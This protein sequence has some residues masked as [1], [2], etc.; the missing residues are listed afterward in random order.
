MAVY[1]IFPEK[2]ATMYTEFP[3]KNTGLDQLLEASTY[4]SEATPQ[5]SRYLIKFPTSQIAEMFNSKI[6]NGEYK[7]YLK[8]FNA[9]VTGLNLDSN[10]EFYPASGDRDW[11]TFQQFD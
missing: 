8:N 10:L 4:L 5:V 7:A 11:E 3:S 6:T 2:D 1:K 9:V